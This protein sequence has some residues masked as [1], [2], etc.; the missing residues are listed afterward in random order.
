MFSRA[1]LTS[2]TVEFAEIGVSNGPP[3]LTVSWKVLTTFQVVALATV[4]VPTSCLYSLLS[5]PSVQKLVPSYPRATAAK[6]IWKLLLVASSVGVAS[7]TT[8]AVLIPAMVEPTTQCL[9]PKSPSP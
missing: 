4:L 6:G 1:R 5:T 3:G 7:G 2:V 8:Q 9:A